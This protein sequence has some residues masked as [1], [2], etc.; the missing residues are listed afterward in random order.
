MGQPAAGRS[1]WYENHSQY[2]EEGSDTALEERGGE[3][4][5]RAGSTNKAQWFAP[6]A[7]P[8]LGTA[9]WGP[10]RSQYGDIQYNITPPWTDAGA[11]HSG[12][13]PD[14]EYDT[15]TS[16]VYQATSCSTR[17]PG[18]AGYIGDLPDKK[19]P[20]R[21]V[22]DASR[23]ADTWKTSVRTHSEWSFVSGG[24]RPPEGPFQV[25]IPM[26]QLDYDVATDLAGDVRAGKWTEI[27]L[28]STTQ[29]WLNGSVKAAKARLSVSYD[30]GKTWSPVSLDKHRTGSWTARFKTPKKAPPRSPSRPTPRPPVASR[31][32]RR[33]SGRSA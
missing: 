20:Y 24:Q 1:F 2:N 25:D 21:L 15:T 27:G 28:S 22:L 31:W 32:T 14:K 5:Y 33:S 11:G 12:S 26:L 3:M 7:R 4:D 29:E 18:R 10:N 6:V 13:M 19:L 16:K 17:P 23:D 30:D 9:Y 8:R